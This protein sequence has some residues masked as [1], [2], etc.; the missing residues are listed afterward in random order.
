MI[1][2]LKGCGATGAVE[3][4][5]IQVLEEI[6]VWTFGKCELYHWI[7]VLDLFDS[8]LQK[9]T[10]RKGVSWAMACDIQD[11]MGHVVS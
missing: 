11:E 2:R 7:D 9:A 6:K 3:L 1:E 5:L 10:Q 4:A 8:I